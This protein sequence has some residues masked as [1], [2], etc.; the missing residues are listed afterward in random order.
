MYRCRRVR[1]FFTFQF[2]FLGKFCFKNKFHLVSRCFSFKFQMIYLFVEF[3]FE[4]FLGLLCARPTNT[5][6]QTHIHS[7]KN[8][9]HIFFPFYTFL[10]DEKSGEKQVIFS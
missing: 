9:V 8:S 10:D 5:S 2:K 6:I 7:Q 4:L 1:D 3:C